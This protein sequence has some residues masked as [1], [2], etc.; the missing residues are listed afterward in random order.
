MEPSQELVEP[1]IGRIQ[2]R[3]HARAEHA[4]SSGAGASQR[5]RRRRHALQ[6]RR[7]PALHRI[8]LSGV[9]YCCQA[10]LPHMLAAQWGRIVILTS[11]ARFGS[12]ERVAYGVSKAGSQR[13]QAR[14][15]RNTRVAASS[16]TASTRPGADGH[17]RAAVRCGVPRQSAGRRHRQVG[18]PGG[19]RGGDRLP[20]LGEQLLCG[21]RRLGSDGRPAGRLSTSRDRSVRCASP[22]TRASWSFSCRRS[23]CLGRA[24]R[25][26][27][28]RELQPFRNRF[29]VTVWPCRQ[30]LSGRSATPRPA[31]R[32]P[33]PARGRRRAS[34][35]HEV[36]CVG[37]ARVARAGPVLGSGEW[38]V[39]SSNRG[40]P[41]CMALR[42]SRRGEN[43][44]R[45]PT[46]GQ[47][48]DSCLIPTRGAAAR[49]AAPAPR[50]GSSTGVCPE[51]G[52]SAAFLK[53][54]VV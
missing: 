43:R 26:R 5:R 1:G 29:A 11:H 19:D 33:P 37:F 52:A 23:S 38:A 24:A 12:P 32:R 35:S 48:L 17:D 54:V 2:S 40:P 49:G 15:E 53:W 13:S 45:G 25:R 10:V 4:A 21:R 20:V 28:P 18:P 42:R 34:T 51:D 31:P 9:M 3:L 41:A 14:S 39:P 46:L 50:F 7:S 16:P 36:T 27:R 47:V 8:N 30:R 22:A 44:S 6:D